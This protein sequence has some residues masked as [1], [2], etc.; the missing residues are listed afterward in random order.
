M[1]TTQPAAPAAEKEWCAAIIHAA[2]CLA[3][4]TTGNVCERGE[5]LL[6]AY[7]EAVQQARPGD[8]Q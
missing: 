2:G 7:A 8:V 6:G 3:C 5:A 1:T 4:R